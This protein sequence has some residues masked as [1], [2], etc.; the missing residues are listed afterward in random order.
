MAQ[1]AGRSTAPLPVIGDPY[2]LEL[3]TED[4]SARR[5]RGILVERGEQDS[6]VG[7]P[8]E[9]AG[10]ASHG[11]AGPTPVTFIS[12]TNAGLFAKKPKS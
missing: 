12:V 11:S 5:C 9:A 8:P 10:E 4:G 3:K 2:Y 1:R 7:I 6:I